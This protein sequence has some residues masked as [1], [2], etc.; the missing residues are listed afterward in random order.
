MKSLPSARPFLLHRGQAETLPVEKAVVRMPGLLRDVRIDQVAMT[1]VGTW[2]SAPATNTRNA[3][4]L[5]F[6]G[7]ALLFCFLN[8]SSDLPSTNLPS[9][10]MASECSGNPSD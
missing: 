7:R 4:Y 9:I 5:N 10:T 8:G 1:F 3:L 6:E 2:S